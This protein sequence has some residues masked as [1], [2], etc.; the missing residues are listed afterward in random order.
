M[1][2]QIDKRLTSVHD[3]PVVEHTLREGLASGVGAELAIET[4]RLADR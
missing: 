2:S 1:K 4:E 3:L